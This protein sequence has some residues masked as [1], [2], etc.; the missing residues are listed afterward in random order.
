MRSYLNHRGPLLR[1]S[2][3]GAGCL[4]F[5]CSNIL[6]I[7]EPMPL[8]VSAGAPSGGAGGALTTFAG[9]DAGGD[10]S[11][12]AGAG[13]ESPSAAGAGGESAGEGGAGGQGGVEPQDGAGASGAAGGGGCVALA[14]QCSGNELQRCEDGAW[15]HDQDC[16]AYC[17]GGA[18]V[19]PPSCAALGTRTCGDT[20]S[21]CRALEVPGGTFI[22]DYDDKTNTSTHFTATV[23]SF[24]MDRFE[25]SVGRLAVFVNAY[26]QVVRKAGDGTSPHIA[27]DVGWQDDFPMPKDSAELKSQLAGCDYTSWD[28][29][30]SAD[31][32]LAANCVSFY[33][34]YAFCIWDQG[35]LPTEAEWNYAAAGGAEQR[36]YPW[37]TQNNAGLD[38]DHAYYGQT[39][40]LPI[41]V[42]TKPEGN[43]RWGHSDLSG[44]VNE[45]VLDYFSKVYPSSE[46][47]DCLNSTPQATRSIR[48]GGFR[49]NAVAQLSSSRT[50]DV[51]DHL[52]SF[53]GFRCVRDLPTLTEK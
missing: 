13:G 45:W 28:D 9:N 7:S 22:R 39:F 2:L 46:C 15:V 53:T 14:T 42:G 23:S 27:G 26:D 34:A 33:V 32:N 40:G 41:D 49:A 21:C 4:G 1:A 3:L 8:E 18:C 10:E 11:G 50:S 37:S 12:G 36:E 52:R 44:N 25:V 20:V 6:G 17:V 38:A 30:E 47:D 29:E 48:G 5:A 19:N 16:A 51:P 24:L 43:G 31:L 35:R